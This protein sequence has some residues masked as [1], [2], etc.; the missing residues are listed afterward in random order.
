MRTVVPCKKS[1][2]EPSAFFAEGEDYRRE[3]MQNVSSVPLLLSVRRGPNSWFPGILGLVC[4]CSMFVGFSAYA[5][6]YSSLPAM[7]K[8]RRMPPLLGRVS[9]FTI[10]V[11]LLRNPV[12]VLM[13]ASVGHDPNLNLH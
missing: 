9:R 1:F 10:T 11:G 12:V 4:M 6:Q 5:G 8:I 3:P 2:H 13:G 7:S